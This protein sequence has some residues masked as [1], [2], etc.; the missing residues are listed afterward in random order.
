MKEVGQPLVH[1]VAAANIKVC[2][3]EGNIS[4]MGAVV[5]FKLTGNLEAI[6]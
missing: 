4:S 5:V 1:F 6:A 2:G 3:D